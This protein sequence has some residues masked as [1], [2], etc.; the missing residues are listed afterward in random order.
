MFEFYLTVSTT[1]NALEV[2]KDAVKY[3]LRINSA[4]NKGTVADT[5]RNIGAEIES[6][7]WHLQH[8]ENTFCKN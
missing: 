3:V 1:E 5:L 4:H 2:L 7:K 6:R 8:S